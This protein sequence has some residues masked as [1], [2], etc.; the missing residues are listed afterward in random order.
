MSDVCSNCHAL[1][2][3]SVL[4]TLEQLYEFTDGQHT[5]FGHGFALFRVEVECSSHYIADSV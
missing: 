4:Y 2:V 1:T 3:E 5:R